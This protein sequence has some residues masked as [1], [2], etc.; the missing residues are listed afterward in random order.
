M[1]RINLLPFR[2]A[3]KKENIRRQ[4]LLFV[5]AFILVAGGLL[6]YNM[7]LSSQVTELDDK[8]RKTKIELARYT[9]ILNEIKQIKR[10]LNILQKKMTVVQS[11]DSDRQKPVRFLDQMAR[12]VIAKRMWF[13][14]LEATAERVTIRGY[15]LDE[16][17]VADF[18]DNLEASRMFASVDL[19]TL[20]QK[21]LQE[22]NLKSFEITCHQIPSE[23]SNSSKAQ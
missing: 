4:I 12:L 13:I 18:L 6:Y 11:L 23:T 2:A 19:K 16:K 8:V 22:I 1:I 9:K 5:L 14:K 7:R 15:A 21:T 20:K 10:E 3:R 17:T